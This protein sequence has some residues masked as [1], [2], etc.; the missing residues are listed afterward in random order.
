MQPPHVVLADFEVDYPMGPIII[1]CFKILPLT[2]R[3]SRV[4]SSGLLC[5]HRILPIS[6]RRP[7]AAVLTAPENEDCVDGW[8]GGGG[9]N[10]EVSGKVSVIRPLMWPDPDPDPDPDRFPVILRSAVAEEEVPP[11]GDDGD[12]ESDALPAED[13]TI[14]N[15]ASSILDDC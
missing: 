11:P 10:A 9:K 1:L 15:L 7:P 14:R 12:G 5:I 4:C 8:R 6:I 3:P 13:A 2:S